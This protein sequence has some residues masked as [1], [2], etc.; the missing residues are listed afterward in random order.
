MLTFLE[1]NGIVLNYSDDEL[2]ALGNSVAEGTV[3]G[4]MIQDWILKR[5]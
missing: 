1:L 4:S 3:N 5:Q 2:I